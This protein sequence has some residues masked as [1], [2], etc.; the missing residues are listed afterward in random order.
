MFD[1]IKKFQSRK[2]MEQRK[3]NKQKPVL[4]EHKSQSTMKTNLARE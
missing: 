3:N 4:A 1:L 2:I